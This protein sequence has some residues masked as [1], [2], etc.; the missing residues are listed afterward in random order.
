MLKICLVDDEDLIRIA[1]TDDLKELGYDVDDFNSPREAL[2]AFRSNH[3]NVVI[4][5]LIMPEMDGLT[6]M[7]EAR[8]S[9]SNC[10]YLVITAFGTVETA[11]EA[12]KAGAYDYI[13]KPFQTEEINLLLKRL[14]ER[15]SLLDENIRLKA[16]VAA[17]T[18]LPN[19]VGKSKSLKDILDLIKTI[20]QS[21][22]SVLITGAT[23]TGKELV[24]EAIHMISLRNNKPMIKVSCAALSR[25][26]LES[27]LFGHVRGAFTGAI[28]KKIGRFELAN[29]STIFLDEV[30]DIPIE[31]QVKLLR[32]IQE[33]EIE[34]VGDTQSIKLDVRIIAATKVNLY[35]R[36]KE[37]KFRQDLYYRLNVVP[38]HLPPLRARSEDIPLLIKHFNIKYRPDNPLNFSP[39]TLDLLMSNPW[40]GN[41]R[42]LE[43][44]IERLSLVC[45]C[46]PV[47]PSCL[48]EKY[49]SQELEN[50]LDDTLGLD[51]QID[52]YQREK[53]RHVL[54]QTNG[55]KSQ[56]ARIL[57]I[58]YS[59]L[60][61]KMEKLNME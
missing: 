14:E 57:R 17:K 28:T 16:E 10:S 51:Y 6:F 1:L 59:T 37:G 21:D 27:E 11:V 52:D 43:N 15:Y 30:D 7:K 42:E 56:A 61:S 18:Q 58:P 46:D 49:F 32:V 36:I 39:E 22:S 23:G 5:D 38:I 20:A 29:R 8:K 4:T 31:L 50:S 53:I 40:E 9:H 34:R 13:T 48:P 25:E 41:I 45:Q 2:A 47:T 24:A 35:D 12:M 26:L 3:Y 19:I 33:K 55:N 44:I 60:R 54:Q